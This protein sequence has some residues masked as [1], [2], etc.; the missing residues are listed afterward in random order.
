MIIA[1]AGHV[2]HGKTSLVK[3]LTQ[4]DTDRLAEEQRRGMSI[5]LGFA[6]ADFGGAVPIG[7]VDV[8]GHERFVR[9]MLAGVACIDLALLVVAADDG[10]MPQTRE[11]LAILS[12]LGVPRCVVALT[13]IDRV[14]QERVLQVEREIAALLADGPY[15]QAPIVAVVA[16]EGSNGSI[17]ADAS[18]SSGA[19]A[20]ANVASNAGT[21]HAATPEGIA[22]LREHLIEA[23]HSLSAR[24]S[25]GHFRLAVDRSFTLA[26]AGRIVTGAALS[27]A[28]RVGDKVVL[29]PRGI[30]ARV[31]GI[32][33]NGQSVDC[34]RA[35]QRCALNL[36]GADLKDAESARGDWIVAP[37]AHAPTHRLDVRIDVLASEA[38][39]LAHGSTLQL[40][41]GAAAV[42]SRIAT[43]EAP[44]I[45]PGA[46]GLAQIVLDAPIAA[47]R[48][49]RFILRDPAANRTVA[50]G[51]V[52]DPFSPARG[53]LKPAR[54]AQL[55]AMSLADPAEA[56]TALL[57]SEPLGI[58]LTRFLLARN[59]TDDEA[60]R[61]LEPL[62]IHVIDGDA[63]RWAVSTARWQK[64]RERV[65]T[66]LS[67]W[68]AEKPDSLGPSQPVLAED[69]GIRGAATVLLRAAVD[70]LV[71][72]V[73]LVRESLRI[74]LATHRAV[75]S[76][77]DSELLAKV[78]ALLLP[79]GL[80]PPIVGE[81]ATRLDRPQPEL[82]DFLLRAGRLG[83]LVRV[84]PNR[85]FLPQTV[86]ELAEHANQLAS[87]SGDR[88]FDAAAFRDRTGIGRNLTVQV[89]EFMDREGL[90][91]FDGKRRKPAH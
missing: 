51:K 6:Y 45:A 67:K 39:P 57:A 3:A 37:A 16:A 71:Q 74:R 21:R 14:G 10:P 35:G 47:L 32:H 53:R 43:L 79:A 66:A 62:A 77:A 78:T 59:L 61:L 72:Q 34:A 84:A 8:P 68:H 55:A 29:S 50:G 2:D 56:L 81:L 83:Q 46:S 25:A 31:R 85:F 82:L 12:L 33:A 54:V 18:A 70:A 27:G 60:G 88:G 91:R 11:H 73:A 20:H 52:L 42:P 24:S 13:E 38:R 23:S 65:C 90:T 58:D 19:T 22:V 49:N 87:E 64:L 41:I 89:L 48:G 5:D 36:A 86:A 9:N 7:F 26:G 69:L 44:A 40:H 1:T 28:A 17:G 75:L 30:S 15:R 63:T 76:A 4:I 80:R